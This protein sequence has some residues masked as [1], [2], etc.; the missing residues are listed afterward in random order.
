M[1]TVKQF[2]TDGLG[3]LEL[4]D[5]DT[6][7]VH[8][9]AQCV[10]QVCVVHNPSDHHMRS[11]DMVWRADKLALAE[12]QCPHGIGHPDPDSLAYFTKVGDNWVG[13]HGCDGCCH[14]PSGPE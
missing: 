13:T 14:V 11:W 7:S 1:D 10:G 8:S 3:M 4:H 12:R 9:P 5:G 2:Y 6:M